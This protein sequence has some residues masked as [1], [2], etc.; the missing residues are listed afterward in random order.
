MF[1][2]HLLRYK[3][4]WTWMDF[5]VH[6][7]NRISACAQ[8]TP[9]ENCSDSCF[10]VLI[11]TQFWE[12]KKKIEKI[13]MGRSSH[14]SFQLFSSNPDRKPCAERTSPAKIESVALLC[15]SDLCSHPL[16]VGLCCSIHPWG[17]SSQCQAIF[18]AFIWA[19]TFKAALE[20]IGCLAESGLWRQDSTR[21][22]V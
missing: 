13:E 8:V 16:G 21:V 6:M 11:C 12:R 4:L 15:G 18:K 14:C 22:K 20:K 10:R 9:V 7:E 2:S 3:K 17:P 1:L 19:A 5:F